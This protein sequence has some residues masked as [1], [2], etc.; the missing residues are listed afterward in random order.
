MRWND[1]AEEQCSVAR[2]V[3]VIG[4]RWTLLILRDCF[5]RVRQF[6]A[7]EISLGITRHILADRLKKLVAH[8]VLKKVPYQERPLRH[9]VPAD[10][11]GARP[12]PRADE[13]RPLG[14]HIHRWHGRTPT[15][16]RAS[17]LWPSIRSCADLFRMRQGGRPAGG[18][19]YAGTGREPRSGPRLGRCRPVRPKLIPT[20]GSIPS[21][22]L[23]LKAVPRSRL[24][25]YSRLRADLGGV[26]LGSIRIPAASCRVCFSLIL[27]FVGPCI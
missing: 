13:H 16:A 23:I 21:P 22:E 2:T 24:Q 15:A 3:S 17:A 10:A 27:P 8:G 6:E 19:G 4:D 9:E 5:L 1:L 14:G 18:A 12:V 20:A 25:V 7:F 11:E 26:D